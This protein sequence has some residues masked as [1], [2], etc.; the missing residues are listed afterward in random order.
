MVWVF[1]AVLVLVVLPL[2]LPPIILLVVNSPI[3]AGDGL[4]KSTDSNVFFSTSTCFSSD[5]LPHCTTRMVEVKF[6]KVFG[7]TETCSHTKSQL[8]KIFLI[9]RGYPGGMLNL[10]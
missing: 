7:Q 1:S 10:N 8:L 3:H 2:P 6:A 4:R 9:P 5:R